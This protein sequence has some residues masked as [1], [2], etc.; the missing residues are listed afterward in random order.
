MSASS[1]SRREY[2]TGDEDD[3]HTFNKLKSSV[4]TGDYVV[5]N[6]IKKNPAKPV[7]VS[8]DTE[9]MGNEVIEKRKANA[10][11]DRGILGQKRKVYIN[12]DV[13]KETRTLFNLT[14]KLKKKHFKFI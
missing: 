10:V 7:L 8:F 5:R 6:I 1:S 14:G 11:I 13:S 2:E 12:D 9:K 4:K 3:K